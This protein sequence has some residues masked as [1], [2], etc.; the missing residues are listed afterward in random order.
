M[1][2]WIPDGD[3][4]FY[5]IVDG[6]GRWIAVVQLNGELTNTQQESMMQKMIDALNASREN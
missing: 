4:N 5:R 2:K 3:A 1:Y 6:G